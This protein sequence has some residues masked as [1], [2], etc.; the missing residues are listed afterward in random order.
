MA[1]GNTAYKLKRS[2]RIPAKAL[3]R[4]QFVA[5]L[6]LG[7][8]P[9]R[10]EV[11]ARLHATRVYEEDVLALGQVLFREIQDLLGERRVIGAGSKPDALE[12]RQISTLVFKN[13]DQRNI[14]RFADGI[15][16]LLRIPVMLGIICDGRADDRL[17]AVAAFAVVSLE[18]YSASN[19]SPQYGQSFGASPAS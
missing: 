18:P 15:E 3:E 19:F 13:V 10:V 16:Q 1:L 5:S 8:L 14:S 6:R 7:Y 12:R 11:N 17:L 9:Y 4:S 2:E